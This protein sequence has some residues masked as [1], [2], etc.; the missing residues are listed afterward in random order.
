[1]ACEARHSLLA[2]DV[3]HILLYSTHSP[4]ALIQYALPPNDGYAVL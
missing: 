1:M 3:A 2:E 4:N